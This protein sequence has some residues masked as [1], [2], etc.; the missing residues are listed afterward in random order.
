MRECIIVGNRICYNGITV[1]VDALYDE[2]FNR[3]S[4]SC[5]PNYYND[6]Y[7]VNELFQY[8]IR[9]YLAIEFF[10]TEHAIES[11]DAR[12]ATFEIKLFVRD[13]ARKKDIRCSSGLLVWEK[14]RSVF[15]YALYH[16]AS[17]LYLQ[18][19]MIRI[20]HKRFQGPQESS[21][22]V[23]RSKA[24]AQKMRKF[25]F[26]YKETENPGDKS[27]VYRYFGRGTRLFWVIKA[28]FSSF[29][30]I[31]AI[32]DAYAPLVG[33]EFRYTVKDYYRSRI[34]HTELFTI[35]MRHYFSYFRGS[36]Y[37]T[38]NNLDRFSVIEER[39]AASYHIKTFNIPHG[40]EY[41]FKF[42]K[43]FS[44]DVFYAYSEYSAGYLNQLYNTNKFVYDESV[45]ERMLKLDAQGESHP[46]YVVFFTE[47][48][49]V[50]V[51][52]DIVSA[53]K[54][55]MDKHGWTLYLKLHPT[56]KKSNYDSLGCPYITDYTASLTGNICI[57]RKSTILLEAI[58]NNSIPIA[59]ITNEKDASIFK[60][61]PSL[62]SDKII[63]R[64]N[65]EDLFQT[66]LELKNDNS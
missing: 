6:S 29:R 42:P 12:K 30:T 24:G 27:S 50:N 33:R 38:A 65:V 7:V 32:N 25:V 11:V 39:V 21:F 54:P 57:S 45:V 1:T 43:G 56:D 19:L 48:R 44:C 31:R 14:T 35:L 63:K 10:L 53:L 37:Y 20:P 2:A 13:I 16:F 49:E 28:Y 34:V 51:N 41:G 17:F 64:Y 9:D 52:L 46:Q 58:Y 23:L 5:A 15:S 18:F 8:R 26:I 55:L 61:F 59:I 66:I 36:N 47:P 40:I 62:N 3:Y 4:D 22:S 60:T